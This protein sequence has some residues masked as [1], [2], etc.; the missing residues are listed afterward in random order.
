MILVAEAVGSNRIVRGQGIVC[1]L[2][3]TGLPPGEERELR[4]GVVRE[5]LGALES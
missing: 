5:A 3:D 2:G 4:R 1:P